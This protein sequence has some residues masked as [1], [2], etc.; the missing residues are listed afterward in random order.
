MTAEDV[1]SWML[2]EVRREGC[3]YQETAVHDIAERFGQQFAYVN[4]NGNMSIHRDVLA[5][6]RALSGDSVVWDKSERL[7][8]PREPFDDPGKRVTE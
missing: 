3:L 4:D 1:A 2:E 6:F 5:A 7:W 8:R